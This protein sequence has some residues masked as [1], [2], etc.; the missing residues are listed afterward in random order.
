MALICICIIV[1]EIKHFFISYFYVFIGYSDII[2]CEVP[3]QIT[4]HF[5]IVVIFL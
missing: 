5:S 2:F 1:D 3:V 4:A